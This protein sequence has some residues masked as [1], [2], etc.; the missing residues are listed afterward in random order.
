[1]DRATAQQVARLA[2]HAVGYLNDALLVARQGSSPEE[3]ESLKQKV[4]AIMGA[5]V[6]DVA[7]PLYAQHPDIVPDE[8]KSSG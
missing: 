3:F 2:T 7:Q 8:L 6:V 4:G 5:I 1:M